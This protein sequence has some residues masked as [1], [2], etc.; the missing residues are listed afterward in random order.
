MLDSSLSTPDNFSKSTFFFSLVA[1]LTNSELINLITSELVSGSLVA[2]LIC[3]LNSLLKPKVALLSTDE[4]SLTSLTELFTFF[5]AF[6]ICPA[7]LSNAPLSPMPCLSIFSAVLEAIEEISS[8]F[9]KSILEI[10]NC[11]FARRLSPRSMT[12]S[13]TDSNAILNEFSILPPAP[14]TADDK[15]VT[16]FMT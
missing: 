9:V 3:S 1:S 6:P 7:T 2:V 5:I 8:M 14:S 12:V 15:A 16:V 13:T 10:S 11:G 4:I